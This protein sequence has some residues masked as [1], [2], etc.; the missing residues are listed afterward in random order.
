MAQES[1][2]TTQDSACRATVAGELLSDRPVACTLSWLIRP[3]LHVVVE[4]VF[5]RAGRIF[6]ENVYLAVS[7]STE[8]G[9][10][11]SFQMAQ[12]AYCLFFLMAD[13]RLHQLT[14]ARA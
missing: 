9:K 11:S 3:T 6:T 4:E 8:N 13:T 14:S 10:R 5:A 7:A 2:A 1:D 12:S